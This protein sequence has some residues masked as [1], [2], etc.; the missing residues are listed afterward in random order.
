MSQ[1]MNIEVVPSNVTSNGSISFKDGNP[2]I[3]FIIGEQDRMLIGNS[4]RFTGKFRAL[5]SSASSSVSDVSNLAMSERLGV[6][7]CIDTLTIKSQKTGQT[8]E[9]IRHYNRFL[10]SYLPVTTSLQDGIGH[11]NESALILPSYA[12]QQESVVNIPSSSSTMNHFCMALP[13][14]LLNGGEPLPL[15]PEALGGLIIELHLSPD[16]QVFHTSGDGDSASYTDSFYEFTDVSLV[17]EL[18]E[19]E[20]AVLQ[21]LKSRQS[22]TY[23]YNSINSYYQTINSGNGIINFQLGLSRVLGVF[24]NIVPAAHINNLE[25]DGLATLYPTNSDATSANIEELFFTRNGSKFPIDFNINT[26]QQT[27]ANNRTADSQIFL[28]YV[29]AIKKFTHNPK[30]TLS[31]INVRLSDSARFDKDF[32]NGGCGFGVGVAYDSISDQGVDFRNVNFGINMR[33]D[34]TTDSPQAFY[35]FVH[36]KQTL[37]FGPQ[38]LQVLA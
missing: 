35:V 6:Y 36:N 3:Q 33:L 31:P 32:A 29:N 13:C 17:A 21:D 24:A 12:A 34:L 2:V 5:L 1:N 38:G 15:M 11:L 27:D 7:S 14:G 23:E 20:A 16:S 28:N 25:F 37:V 10:S 26:L 4:L 19:P 18:M 30:S 9:S 22:A 8:I